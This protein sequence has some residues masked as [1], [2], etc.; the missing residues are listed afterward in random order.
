LSLA[1]VSDGDG[2][3]RKKRKARKKA[4]R[5]MTA[6]VKSAVPN[7]GIRRVRVIRGSKQE[8]TNQANAANETDRHG[9]QDRRRSVT[10]ASS[11][12]P[13]F[14]SLVAARGRAGPIREIRGQSFHH[15]S[16]GWARISCR[17]GAA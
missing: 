3:P 7:R 10:S 14:L 15:G 13:V 12:V 11:V 5:P 17:V 6:V 2:E 1:Q 9:H 16:H 8:T 4:G